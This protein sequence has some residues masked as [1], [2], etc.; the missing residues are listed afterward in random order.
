M[1]D[2]IEEPKATRKKQAL[3]AP[4]WNG[5]N[6]PVER[7]KMVTDPRHVL[8]K[9]DC[10]K[11][12]DPHLVRR[13]AAAGVNKPLE[14]TIDGDDVLIVEGRSRYRAV[15]EVINPQR[16]KEGLAPIT[17]LPCVLKKGSESDLIALMADGNLARKT[18]AAWSVAISC[19]H[20]L[21]QHDGEPD[22][23]AAAADLFRVSESTVRLWERYCTLSRALQ[24]AVEAGAVG[25]AAAARMSNQSKDEQAAHAEAAM[26]AHAEAGGRKRRAKGRKKPSPA[27]IGEAAE[28]LRSGK[29]RVALLWATG[30]ASWRDL[31]AEF[32]ELEG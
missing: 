8:F 17:H 32:P 10:L 5:F 15:V 14:V 2:T 18:E 24:R 30:R 29:A 4:R 23:I 6:V 16:E 19:G 28:K 22:R 7:L 1:T 26:A 25:L 21:R 13:I 9:P 20:W 11:P 3:D 27:A 12:L 31:V